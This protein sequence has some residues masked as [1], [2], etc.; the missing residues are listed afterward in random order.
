MSTSEQVARD[1]PVEL[2]EEDLDM[3]QVGSRWHNWLHSAWEVS[4][5]DLDMHQAKAHERQPKAANQ[6]A[7]EDGL[8]MHQ[9]EH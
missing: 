7:L 2:A 5:E 1:Q 3:H 9:T 6:S 4:Q 8:D